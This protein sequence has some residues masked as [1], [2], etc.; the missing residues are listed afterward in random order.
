MRCGRLRVSAYA[1]LAT[2]ALRQQRR[3]LWKV[4]PKLHYLH[5]SDVTKDGR[6][7]PMSLSNF[8]DEENVKHLRAVALAC[9]PMTSKVA[10]ARRYILK[11]VLSLVLALPTL[12]W[13]RGGSLQT[14]EQPVIG[15]LVTL[16]C[17]R[18]Q[19]LFSSQRH[20]FLHG[21][22]PRIPS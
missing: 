10:W 18:N 11:R 17:S 2:E 13:G 4:R 3:L 15:Q 6:G 14:Q 1:A 7:N 8:L 16:R 5:L 21:V 20:R 19:I 9:S 22:L 12:A